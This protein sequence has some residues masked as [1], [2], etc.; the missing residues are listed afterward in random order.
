MENLFF[1]FEFNFSFP[2]VK[3]TQKILV[4]RNQAKVRSE[5]EI[6]NGFLE[7]INNPVIVNGV[8]KTSKIC[9]KK[10]K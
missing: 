8:S 3:I 6:K 2:F 1:C 5:G 10:N 4:P 9:F 7:H